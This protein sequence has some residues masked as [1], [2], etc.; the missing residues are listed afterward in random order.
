[1]VI[2]YES[3]KFDPENFYGLDARTTFI[4]VF[5]PSDHLHFICPKCKEI[6]RILRVE[7]SEIHYAKPIYFLLQCPK[8]G[9]YSQRKIYLKE[10]EARENPKLYQLASKWPGKM[11]KENKHKTRNRPR[12]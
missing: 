1:M 6:A 2:I 5:D 8:C 4:P 7:L 11:K 10:L 12:S 9:N 3:K